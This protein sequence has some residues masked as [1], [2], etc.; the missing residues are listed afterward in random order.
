MTLFF[1]GAIAMAY[2]MV[3]LFF[4]RFWKRS[5]DRLFVFFAIAFW[6]LALQRVGLALTSER[7]EDDTFFYVIRLFAFVLIL[8][9][10]WDKNRTGAS[11]DAQE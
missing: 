2:L 11:D 4:L 3:G 8:V 10:I 6:I 1:S 5:R 7:L 9:A